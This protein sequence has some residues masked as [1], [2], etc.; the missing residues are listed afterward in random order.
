MRGAR[1]SQIEDGDVCT[2]DIPTRGD[3]LVRHLCDIARR[4][5]GTQKRTSYDCAPGD[6]RCRIRS[7]IYSAVSRQH[8]SLWLSVR[9]PELHLSNLSPSHQTLR[10]ICGKFPCFREGGCSRIYQWRIHVVAALRVLSEGAGY[11]AAKECDA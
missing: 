6:E 11:I 1:F 7:V 4:S 5:A 8:T 2:R 10:H 3:H 9:K